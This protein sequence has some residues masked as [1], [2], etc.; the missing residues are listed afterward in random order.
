MA[1]TMRRRL[2]L[3]GVGGVG[4]NFMRLMC[5]HEDEV[6][7][8]IFD[9]DTV[10][11]HNLNRASMFTIDDAFSNAS[12]VSA[13]AAS[14]KR[15]ASE[16]SVTPSNAEIDRDTVLPK[17]LVI[18]ARDTLNPT[19]I[20]AATWLK[21]AYDGG[22]EMSFTWLPHIVSKHV[23]DLSNG[24]SNAYAVVPSFYVPAALLSILAM[25]FMQ[26]ENFLEITEMRAG[27]FHMNLDEMVD[28]VSYE[29]E[30]PQ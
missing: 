6:M 21:L 8:R 26:F 17:G 20:P 1:N 13:I 2:N 24:R 7:V 15:L 22:S 10:E 23:V 29:W 3:L 30:P 27:T 5:H 12:K 25:R 28:S 11:L 19:K 4:S 9:M 18:D 14:C 16:L